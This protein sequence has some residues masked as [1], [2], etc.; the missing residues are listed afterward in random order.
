MKV[1]A[2][3]SGGVDSSFIVSRLLDEGHN[4]E[5]VTLNLGKHSAATIKRAQEVAELFKIK[6]HVLNVED[7]FKSEIIDFFEEGY[8]SGTTPIPCAK[9]NKV[10]KFGALLDFTIKNNAQYLATGHYARILK[11]KSGNI[12][13]HKA[14][15]KSKDQTHFLFHINK[16]ALQYMMFPLGNDIKANIKQ[17]AA[18]FGI[19]LDTQSESQDICFL[20]NKPYIDFFDKNKNSDLFK[21]GEIRHCETNQILGTHHGV[22]RYTIGQRRAIG[23]SYNEPLYVTH[24]DHMGNIVYVGE[25][26]HLYINTIQ[27]KELNIL[28]PEYENLDTFECEV[29]TR[30]MKPTIKANIQINKQN[31]TAQITLDKPER[32]I[33]KGQAC[34]MYSGERL[35]GGGIIF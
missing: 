22:I 15:D 3:M 9:C 2:A 7:K 29:S 11:G 12:E 27:I 13:I 21:E 28:A 16:N 6:H 34:V 19:G 4:V 31:Q 20:E 5:G 8:S 18:Q 1:F 23:V 30:A 32:A 14:I 17:Q 33:T 35:L 10:I 26:K 24:I 25:E